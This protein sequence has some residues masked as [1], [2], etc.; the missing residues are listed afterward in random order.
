MGGLTIGAQGAA[1]GL[2]I[3]NVGGAVITP[4][5]SAMNGSISTGLAAARET[6]QKIAA[7]K[8]KPVLVYLMV[9]LTGSRSSTRSSMR[10]HERDL[11]AKI[12]AV[13]GEHPVIC[14]GV[15]HRG[16]QSSKPILLKDAKAIENFFDTDPIG[17]GTDIEPGLNH[18]LNDPTDAVVSLGIYIGDSNDGDDEDTLLELATELKKK[19]RPLI[20]AFERGDC[21]H[22]C[23]NVAPGMANASEG[24]SF[25]LS[26][27]PDELN[28]LLGNIRKVLETTP[29]QLRQ[30]ANSG[31][32]HFG[33]TAATQDLARRIAHR[34]AAPL[35]I[36]AAPR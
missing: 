31:G 12:R 27:N 34:V 2:K 8:A 16:G 6:A 33:G 32:F 3:G 20:V 1:S 36:T 29:D 25:Q 7:F 35:M 19:D 13:G 9:D 28:V 23:N 14:K 17:G 30:Q 15:Y 26:Q 5:S 4:P 21:N 11:A 10:P 24:I 18:Y 22:F